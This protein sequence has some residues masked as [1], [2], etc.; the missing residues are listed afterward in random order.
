M[1]GG[2]QDP[3]ADKRLQDQAKRQGQLAVRKRHPKANIGQ[4]DD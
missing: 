4:T 3:V 1:R 2:V